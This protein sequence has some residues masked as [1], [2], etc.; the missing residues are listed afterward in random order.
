MR[1]GS[2][3]AVGALPQGDLSKSRAFPPRFYA[4]EGIAGAATHP[5]SPRGLFP[6]PLPGASR[7]E[8]TPRP[9]A[10]FYC[11][12]AWGYIER[13]IDLTAEFAILI[14][15]DMKTELPVEF[16]DLIPR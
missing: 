12:F 10:G 9:T 1:G 14:V 11:S 6:R 3:G 16:D 15:C 13:K 8:T 4:P 5:A 7:P 2:A